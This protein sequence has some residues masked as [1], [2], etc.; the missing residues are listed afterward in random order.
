M[1]MN[2]NWVLCW[3]GI[4]CLK[5]LAP[6]KGAVLDYN[7]LHLP[8]NSEKLSR[9]PSNSPG[10][11]N[12]NEIGSDLHYSSQSTHC[13]KS[14]EGMGVIWLAFELP[15]P[16]VNTT[17]VCIV[18]VT[19]SEKICDLICSDKTLMLRSSFNS[20][21]C[22]VGRGT[23]TEGCV[24]KVFFVCVCSPAPCSC[25][26]WSRPTLKR[27]GSGSLL[28]D[29]CPSRDPIPPWKRGDLLTSGK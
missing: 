13:F 24:V 15:P 2:R 19:T 23:G 8:S 29:A 18:H 11:L 1:R 27:W 21:F 14:L 12:G 7:L 5:C 4:P 20:R 26:C 16:L 17:P 22:W 3:K 9:P 28:R 10:S 25:W 6:F